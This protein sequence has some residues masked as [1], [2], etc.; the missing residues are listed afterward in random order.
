[1][2]ESSNSKSEN[3]RIYE[4]WSSIQDIIGPARLWPIQIRRN[5][6]T[7]GLKHWQ[8][9][10]TAV[11][12]FING[13]NPSV[14]MEWAHLLNLGADNKAY[15]HFQYLLTTFEAN[16]R[17]YNLYGYNVTNNR[18]EYLSGNVRVYVNKSNR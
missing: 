11:F 6:W 2:S 8:R 15:D 1:M 13:L 10:L 3:R 14:F 18:Y 9:T 5:F 7:P 12:V 4:L 16:P 17:R